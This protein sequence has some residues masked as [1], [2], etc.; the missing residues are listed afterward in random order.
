MD[1]VDVS[2]I[3]ARKSG[4]HRQVVSET[5]RLLQMAESYIRLRRL[6]GFAR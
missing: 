4:D 3:V 6:N 1:P 2:H 5:G